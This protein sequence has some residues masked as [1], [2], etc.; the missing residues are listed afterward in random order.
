VHPEGSA[1]TPADELRTIGPCIFAL[2]R[3]KGFPASLSD[4]RAVPIYRVLEV[5]TGAA[6]ISIGGPE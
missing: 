1:T 4:W 5:S 6:G 2:H 3:L